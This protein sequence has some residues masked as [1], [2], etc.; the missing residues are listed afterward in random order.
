MNQYL[1]S[2]MYQHHAKQYINRAHGMISTFKGHIFHRGK[3]V[4]NNHETNTKLI[5]TEGIQSS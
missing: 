4:T 3:Y 2:T 5:K 1:S